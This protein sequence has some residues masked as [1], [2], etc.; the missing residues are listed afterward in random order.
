MYGKV[1]VLNPNY[2]KKMPGNGVFGELNPSK[3]LDVRKKLSKSKWGDLNPA[4]RPEVRQKLRDAWI[5]R[6]MH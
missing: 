3:R 4:K 2:G 1:G 6:R 5:K